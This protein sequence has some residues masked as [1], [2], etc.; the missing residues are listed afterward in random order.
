MSGLATRPPQYLLTG[1]EV[2]DL[3]RIGK[4]TLREWRLA[5]R[6][7]GHRAHDRAHWRYPADQ[8]VI[9]DALAAVGERR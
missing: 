3:L 1:T 5:G 9:R 7:Q 4:T 6:I 8:N 2:R